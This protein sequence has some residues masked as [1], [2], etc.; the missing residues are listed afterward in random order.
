[1]TKRL[2]I[3]KRSKTRPGLTR[4]EQFVSV[5]DDAIES[6]RK[7]NSPVSGGAIVALRVVR[8]AYASAFGL[9]PSL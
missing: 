5:L 4:A 7:G 8:E 3:K 9:P 2:K 6:E 1:M